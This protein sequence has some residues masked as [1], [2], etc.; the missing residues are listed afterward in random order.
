MSISTVGLFPHFSWIVVALIV[1]NGCAPEEKKE[2]DPSTIN[3]NVTG[4]NFRTAGGCTGL[5]VGQGSSVR[6]YT[7][8]P[9]GVNSCDTAGSTVIRVPV[10]RVILSGTTQIPWLRA[11]GVHDRVIGFPDPGL[12]HDPE[13]VARIRRGYVRDVGGPSGLD[14]EQV[15]S[16][17]PDLVLAYP[18]TDGT[19][20]KVLSANGIPVV[21]TAEMEEAHP[22]GRAEWIRLAGILFGKTVQADSIFK[23]IS[24][25]YRALSDSVRGTGHSP[26]VMTGIPYG[27]TWFIPGGRNFAAT[28]FRD[29]GFDY[30]WSDDGSTGTLQLGFEAVYARALKA[31]HWIGLGH[32]RDLASML[33]DEPRFRDLGPLRTGNLYTYSLDGSSAVPNPYFEE[34]TLRSDLLL[35]DLVLIRAGAPE[36]MLHY[37]RRLR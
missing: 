24:I 2:I 35:R 28:L 11:L 15:L 6:R 23:A 3:G 34:A 10:Q 4:F 7:L 17:K 36:K 31:D 20:E 5:T 21:V 1:L 27:G 16:L 32:F 9:H 33:T 25:R 37:Y 12:I 26:T 13:I 19:R 18:S 29:A 8:V 22:L 30:L 14:A